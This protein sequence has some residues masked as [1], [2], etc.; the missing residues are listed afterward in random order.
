[1]ITLGAFNLAASLLFTTFPGASKADRE[2]TLAAER[3]IADERQPAHT[4][5]AKTAREE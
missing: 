5:I 4:S 2:A 1:M 3:S